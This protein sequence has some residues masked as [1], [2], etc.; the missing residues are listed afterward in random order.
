MWD[1]ELL[2]AIDNARSFFSVFSFLGLYFAPHRGLGEE[3]FF[4]TDYE[5]PADSGRKVFA[6]ILSE[7]ATRHKERQTG[8]SNLQF[9]KKGQLKWFFF[10]DPPSK[11]LIEHSCFCSFFDLGVYNVYVGEENFG[12]LS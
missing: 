5:S 9:L 10:V 3:I 8:L 4:F 11:H 1:L 12:V 7:S 2:G 6:L